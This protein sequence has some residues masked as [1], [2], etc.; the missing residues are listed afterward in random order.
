MC[1]WEV[2][3]GLYYKSFRYFLNIHSFIQDNNNVDC[4]SLLPV[5]MWVDASVYKTPQVSAAFLNA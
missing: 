1:H 3:K 2:N 4:M 5:F